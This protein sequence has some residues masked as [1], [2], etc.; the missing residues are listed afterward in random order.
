M[1]S[2]HRFEHI[3]A[4]LATSATLPTSQA[5]SPSPTTPAPGGGCLGGDP[6][7]IGEGA[8]VGGD[9]DGAWEVGEVADVA[10]LA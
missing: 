8:G 3:Y 9:G 5:T 6:E 10:R 7:G 1:W 4:S 2:L